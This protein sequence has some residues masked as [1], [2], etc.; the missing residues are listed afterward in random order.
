MIEHLLLPFT[1]YILYMQKYLFFFIIIILIFPSINFNKEKKYLTID[2]WLNKNDSWLNK[3]K[4]DI[5]GIYNYVEKNI[6]LYKVFEYIENRQNMWEKSIFKKKKNGKKQFIESSINSIKLK[7]KN[8]Y[9]ILLLCLYFYIS[10]KGI[11]SN[12]NDIEIIEK[13]HDITNNINVFYKEI[14]KKNII[15]FSKLTYEDKYIYQICYS[16]I[17]ENIYND[18]YFIKEENLS[19]KDSSDSEKSYN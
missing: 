7:K 6:D 13:M 5:E 4:Y 9:S 16:A 12:I 2:E 19:D 10:K 11:E 15:E 17:I 14:E 18:N 8:D 1:F 3:D